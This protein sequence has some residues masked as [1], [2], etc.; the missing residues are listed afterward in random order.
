M[1]KYIEKTTKGF[2]T[3]DLTDK[4]DIKTYSELLNN[5]RVKILSS[6]YGKH[7]EST[8]DGEYNNTVKKDVLHVEYEECDL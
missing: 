3:F 2:L 5:P 6:K 1:S 7:E 4:D 8:Q